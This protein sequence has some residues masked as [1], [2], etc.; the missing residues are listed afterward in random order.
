MHVMILNDDSEARSQIAKAVTERFP[1]AVVLESDNM[2]DACKHTGRVDLLIVDVSAVAPIML[3]HTA[4]SPICTWI[5]QH[6]GCEVI[7]DS[8][9]P[10]LKYI[11]QDVLERIPEA[12]IEATDWSTLNLESILDRKA[13]AAKEA[14][15]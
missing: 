8:A 14:V 6:P 1:C 15:K 5:E 7:I 2:L 12:L 13:L 10:G 11:V 9:C 3:N 4:Y